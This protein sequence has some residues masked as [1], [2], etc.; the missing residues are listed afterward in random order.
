[1]CSLT[2]S[3]VCMTGAFEAYALMDYPHANDHLG[4]HVRF[5]AQVCFGIR[6]DKKPRKKGFLG[7]ERCAWVMLQ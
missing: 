1:M 4:L 6:S 3:T 5:G 2:L 7:A